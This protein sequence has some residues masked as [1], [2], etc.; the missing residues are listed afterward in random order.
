MS[1][2]AYVTFQGQCQDTPQG[3]QLLSVQVPLHHHPFA[4]EQPP[5]PSIQMW[6]THR[7]LHGSSR[8]CPPILVVTIHQALSAAAEI[9]PCADVQLW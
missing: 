2:A 5:E 6:F 1:H 4:V 8:H 7:L 3:L 9:S